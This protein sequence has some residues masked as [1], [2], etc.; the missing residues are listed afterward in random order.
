MT[1][2]APCVPLR[3]ACLGDSLTRGDGTHERHARLKELTGRGNYPAALQ[4]L[5][6]EHFKVQNFGHGGTT[7]CNLSDAPFVRT[8]EFRRAISFRPHVLIL[9]LGTN[10]AKSKNWPTT[11]C[12]ATGLLRGL[13]DIISAMGKPQPPTLILDPPPILRER[14]RIRKRYLREVQLTVRRQFHSN[15]T[16]ACRY[17][18][19]WRSRSYMEILSQYDGH[20]LGRRHYVGDGVHLSAIGSQ[21]L[22]C[23][24]L[25]ALRACVGRQLGGSRICTFKP[26]VALCPAANAMS[27]VLRR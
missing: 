1:E 12:G 27:S 23:A 17:G 11:T 15:H 9:M 22:S 7:A 26:S 8:R 2:S 10:D 18:S 19:Q 25:E 14:W 4:R 3:I 24:S 6:G 16:A 5:L 21:Q 13:S 20:E